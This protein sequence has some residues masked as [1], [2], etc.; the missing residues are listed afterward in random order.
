[1]F[2]K[3]KYPKILEIDEVSLVELW[4]FSDTPSVLRNINLQTDNIDEC[5]YQLN[6]VVPEFRHYNHESKFTLEKFVNEWFPKNLC[7]SKNCFGSS[8][9]M[10][11]MYHILS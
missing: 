8:K 10:K 1:M 6:I 2:K 4:E 5:I 11:K 9:Y 3:S 7:M